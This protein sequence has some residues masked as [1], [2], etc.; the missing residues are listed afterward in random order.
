MP[1]IRVAA[2]R[3]FDVRVV[4][5]TT[6]VNATELDVIPTLGIVYVEAPAVRDS[7]FEPARHHPFVLAA[8]VDIRRNLAV[9]RD[10]RPVVSEVAVDVGE[11]HAADVAHALR[12]ENNVA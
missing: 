7:R 3:S 12:R 10:P 2:I 8:L 11:P 5:T 1:R 6:P 9:G 4:P